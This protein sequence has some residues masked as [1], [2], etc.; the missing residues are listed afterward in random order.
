[1]KKMVDNCIFCNIISG[2]IK[3][4]LVYKDEFVTAFKDIAPQAPTH[5]IIV[6][7]EHI[8]RIE[9]V[10]NL[11]VFSNIFKAINVIIDNNSNDFK[12]GFRIVANSGKNGGQTIWHVHFHLLAGRQMIWPPG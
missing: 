3:S 9:N 5:I 11:Q 12:D 2:K 4:D 10:K 6:P 8:E 1:M 7:N